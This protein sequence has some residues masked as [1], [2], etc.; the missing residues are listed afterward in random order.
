MVGNLLS[1]SL[2]EKMKSSSQ[3]R[4]SFLATLS[5]QINRSH[6]GNMLLATS[7]TKSSPELEYLLV[8]KTMEDRL[9]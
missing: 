4:E 9:I 7:V 6:K 8:I 3:E 2:D 5:I 1:S